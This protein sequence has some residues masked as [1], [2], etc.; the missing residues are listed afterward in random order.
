MSQRVQ[1]KHQQWQAMLQAEISHAPD[2]TRALCEPAT[3]LNPIETM[4]LLRQ[5]R[6]EQVASLSPPAVA[7]LVA[8][9]RE[10]TETLV[11]ANPLL[12][13]A[14]SRTGKCKASEGYREP[15]GH[16]HGDMCPTYPTTNATSIVC[17]LHVTRLGPVVCVCVY[18]RK[19]LVGRQWVGRPIC[20][21]AAL[22][23]RPLRRVHTHTGILGSEN[24][25]VWLTTVPGHPWQNAHD[26]VKPGA[27]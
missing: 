11:F 2:T 23:H 27:L 13:E 12:R 24:S 14:L 3:Q 10:R 18:L 25:T 8:A 7:R 5:L 15:D 9:F 17:D 6:P 19:Y 26:G 4:L 16:V 22:A 20:V 1:G 21:C